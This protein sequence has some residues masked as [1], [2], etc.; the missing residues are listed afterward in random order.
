MA[1]VSFFGSAFFLMSFYTKCLATLVCALAVIR[2]KGFPKLSK[3][4]FSEVLRTEFFLNLFYILTLAIPP[5]RHSLLF[6][7]PLGIHFLSGTAEYLLSIEHA[8]L[9]ISAIK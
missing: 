8:I 9:K 6:F 4:Y 1:K 5:G 3:Q 2:N 7:L